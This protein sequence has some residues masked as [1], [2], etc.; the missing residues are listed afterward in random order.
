MDTGIPSSLDSY[1][2]PCSH[3]LYIGNS[4][5]RNHRRPG[6]CVT[7]TSCWILKKSSVLMHAKAKRD[8][9]KEFEKLYLFVNLILRLKVYYQHPLEQGLFLL[10]YLAWSLH[11]EKLAIAYHLGLCCKSILLITSST[12]EKVQINKKQ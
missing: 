10:F 11:K 7:N 3:D 5:M 2:V 1:F 12:V 9:Q 4:T 8:K 6:N